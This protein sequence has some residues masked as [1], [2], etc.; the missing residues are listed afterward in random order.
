MV[1]WQIIKRKKIHE[2]KKKFDNLKAS[3]DRV[4]NLNRKYLN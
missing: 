4:L 3:G 1:Q 2:I